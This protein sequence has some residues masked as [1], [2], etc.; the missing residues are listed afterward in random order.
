MRP[1]IASAENPAAAHVRPRKI[2]PLAEPIDIWLC[3]GGAAY[4][5]H[6]KPIGVAEEGLAPPLWLLVE[7]PAGVFDCARA[8]PSSISIVLVE[9]SGHDYY[10]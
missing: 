1:R 3:G 9:Q 8:T 5:A 6:Q 4:A 10:S 7:A 2:P